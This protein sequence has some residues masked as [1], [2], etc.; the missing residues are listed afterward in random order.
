MRACIVSATRKG[1]ASPWIAP[2]K[3][4]HAGD[5]E[6]GE[7]EVGD[8]RPA[9]DAGQRLGQRVAAVHLGRPIGA[10]DERRSVVDT[11]DALEDRDALGVGPVE[12]VED[13]HR[14]STADH[15]GDHGARRFQPGRQGRLRIVRATQRDQPV[16]VDGELVVEGVEEQLEGTAE[17]PGIGLTG[18]HQ[19]VVRQA[20]HELTHEPGLAD[21]GL[22]ADQCDARHGVREEGAQLVELAGPSHHHRAQTGTPGQHG[23]SVPAGQ[24]ARSATPVQHRFRAQGRLLRH[25]RS[26]PAVV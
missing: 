7:A 24:R 26:H 18:E 16:V 9:L 2:R 8:R 3:I 21:A 6:P 12:V 11:G 17:A 14:G 1:T 19:G 15:V 10:D 5:V 23:P 13:E 20:R 4:L 25:R 22:A